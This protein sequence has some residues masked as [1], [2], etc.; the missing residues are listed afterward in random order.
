[1][2]YYYASLQLSVIVLVFIV[3]NLIVD[4]S[5]L[6]ERMDMTVE[7]VASSVEVDEVMT[8]SLKSNHN[9]IGEILNILEKLTQT[10]MDVCTTD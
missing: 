2:K 9:T 1:M 3:G 4:V 10:V 8:E 6:E 5:L 7:V